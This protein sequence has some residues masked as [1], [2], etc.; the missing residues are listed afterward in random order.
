MPEVKWEHKFPDSR[1]ETIQYNT[2]YVGVFTLDP[3]RR[4]YHE[5]DT[6]YR[7]VISGICH[8][9]FDEIINDAKSNTSPY[10]E[11][12]GVTLY[13]WWAIPHYK[14]ML[15]P[16]EQNEWIEFSLS[17]ETSP[18]RM[19]LDKFDYSITRDENGLITGLIMPIPHINTVALFHLFKGIRGAVE[20]RTLPFLHAKKNG[21]KDQQLLY[22][23]YVLSSYFVSL[24]EDLDQCIYSIGGEHQPFKLELNDN[25]LNSNMICNLNHHSL[26][27]SVYY[28]G[29]CNMGTHVFGQK[30]LDDSVHNKMERFIVENFQKDGKKK[31]NEGYFLK[32][33]E[34]PYNMVHYNVDL[35][36]FIENVD[37][38]WE[39]LS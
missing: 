2:N 21:V 12:I 27:N 29:S 1:L 14:G 8:K 19:M 5:K 6:P 17:P 35:D 33:I 23:L 34:P 31:V 15:T 39:I 3:V 37:K 13:M 18:W 20:R 10:K 32:I 28:Y 16:T 36:L 25:V 22:K 38:I 4:L 26:L 9:P 30:G 24:P 7:A 11:N